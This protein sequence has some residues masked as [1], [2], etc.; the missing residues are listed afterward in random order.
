MSN[1][2]KKIHKTVIIGTGPSGLTAA[3]YTARADMEPLVLEGPEPGGQLTLTTDVDNFPGFPEGILGPE[4]IE[5]MKKQS[6][7]FG[8]KF[9]SVW[10]TKVDFS[11]SPYRI[12]ND[13]G[14]H[15]L[16]KTIIISTGASA[17]L[18]GLDGE[19][20][21]I[22]KGISTCA[23][24]DGFFF[25]DK[26]IYVVGGGD[27]AMEDANFLTKFAAKV[28]IVH[29]RDK[30]RA[31]KVMQDRSFNN[32]KI[33]FIWNSTVSK[34]LSNESGVTGIVLKNLNNNEEKECSTDG[35]FYAIGHTPNTAFLEGQISLDDHGFIKTTEMAVDTNIEG[36][37]A[38]GDVQDSYFRQAITAAGSG[39]QAAMRSERYLENLE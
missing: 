33:E 12:Y 18:L 7:R 15:Y 16:A 2:E 1:S 28:Y 25:R 30:L 10:A 36:V 4:L 26:T 23:T 38:C 14:D 8:A 39:C 21:L 11:S 17:K 24:C 3:L 22:G 32:P 19:K 5:R 29:R 35:L 31:S 9:E 6:M 37:F 27:T 20:A 13:K 34:V